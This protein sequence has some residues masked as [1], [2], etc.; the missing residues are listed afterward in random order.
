MFILLPYPP[1]STQ[2]LQ[3][4]DVAVFRPMKAHWRK[5]FGNYRAE[6]R[7]TGSI[8][9]EAFPFLLNQLWQMIKTKSADSIRNGFAA[10]GLHPRNVNRPLS[11]LPG[12][13]AAVNTSVR[14]IR[15]DLDNTLMDML[16][17]RRGQLQKKK[18]RGK[19]VRCC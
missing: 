18:S 13:A 5:I 15:T 11:K 19:K 16:K 12:T 6:T 2:L 1:N 8:H 14:A 10:T 4:L 17:E 3:P 9:K 7:L